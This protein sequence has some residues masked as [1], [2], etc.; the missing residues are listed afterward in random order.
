MLIEPTAETWVHATADGQRAI[1]R[2]V[3]PG[4][5]LTLEARQEMAFRIGNAG[6]FQYSINGV[7]GRVLGASG[8]VLEF[9]VTRDNL[10]T[11]QQ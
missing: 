4:E 11:Y 5:R 1:Y 3:K 6:A 7:P 2:L 8:E 9:Q 10:L